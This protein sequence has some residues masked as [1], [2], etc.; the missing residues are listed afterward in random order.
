[1]ARHYVADKEEEEDRK[2][3]GEDRRDDP[4][5]NDAYDAGRDV[6]LLRG[7]LL[8][9]DDAVFA[10]SNNGHADHATNAG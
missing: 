4:R 7:R 3:A 6:K 8:R 5:E 10:L 9:P 1:M 2:E